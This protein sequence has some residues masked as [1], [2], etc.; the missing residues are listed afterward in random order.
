MAGRTLLI[1]ALIVG[2][3]PTAF[4]QLSNRDKTFV[5]NAAQ[6]INYQIRAAL[7]VDKYS[8]NQVYRDYAIRVAN[9]QTEESGELQFMVADEDT[10][11]R[12]PSGVSPTGQRQ[13][14]ALK[15]ARNVDTTYRNQTIASLG[16]MLSLYQTYAGQFDANPQLKKMAQEMLPIIQ[17]E[18]DDATNL[19]TTAQYV[20]P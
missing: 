7:L 11:V 18:L 16:A 6:A 5:M 20:K 4:A 17:K 9:E 8:S 13:L 1:A 14:D 19:L 15:N 12:L 3:V 10:S 2:L